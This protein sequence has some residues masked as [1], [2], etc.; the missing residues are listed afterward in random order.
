MKKKSGLPHKVGTTDI[1]SAELK[2][3]VMQFMENFMALD[4]RVGAAEAAV[5]ELQKGGE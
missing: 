5:R 3:V 4:R 2:K 1:A